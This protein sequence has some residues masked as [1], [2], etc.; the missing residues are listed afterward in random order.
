[1]TRYFRTPIMLSLIIMVASAGFLAGCAPAVQAATAT[2]T[3][4]PRAQAEQASVVPAT[5]TPVVVA[6]TAA[7][8]AE[9]AVTA[10][11]EVAAPTDVPATE[12]PA[13][14]VSESNAASTNPA[15]ASEAAAAPAALPR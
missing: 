13:A 9:P 5:E 10:T 4:T 2:P 12:T 1:M 11:A 14:A 7:P 15:A 8:A 6:T 3:K